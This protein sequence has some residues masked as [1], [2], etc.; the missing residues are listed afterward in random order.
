MTEVVRSSRRPQRTMVGILLVMLSL[1]GL[2]QAGRATGAHVIYHGLKYSKQTPRASYEAIGGACDLAHRLYPY[3]YYLCTLAGQT[4]YLDSRV[5]D[6]EVHARH[7]AKAERW[8][9][10]S[11]RLNPFRSQTRLL[12]TRLLQSD[13]MEEAIAY[14][15]EYVDW[16][17]WDPYNHA[18]LVDLHLKA[19]NI[20]EAIT[21]LQ[22]VEGS[23]SYSWA[24]SGLH[25]AWARD[26]AMP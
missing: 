25:D 1:L 4:A 24:T 12:K 10:A 8:C 26:S 11:L 16:E 9:A 6:P 14:W 15:S 2:W 19:G 3:N 23:D 17:F 13:S 18:I 7:K 5:R 22:W 20:S 21:E